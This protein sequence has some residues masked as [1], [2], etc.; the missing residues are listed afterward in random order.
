MWRELF[1]PAQLSC[2]GQSW[3]KARTESSWVMCP[4]DTSSERDRNC[5]V[6]KFLLA[7]RLPLWIKCCKKAR[8]DRAE[9]LQE[10]SA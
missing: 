7:L 3:G 5:R 10:G 6:W 9:S 8:G 1:W 4:G 2:P